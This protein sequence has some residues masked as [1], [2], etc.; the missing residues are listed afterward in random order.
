LVGAV[1]SLI[2]V[3]IVLLAIIFAGPIV[4]GDP[5]G[6]LARLGTGVML[7]LALALTPLFCSA[8]CGGVLIFTRRLQVGRQIEL[9]A[10]SGRIVNVRL[11]DTVL[12][13]NDGSEVRVPHLRT[14]LTP[15]RVLTVE[16]RRSVELSITTRIEP[17]AVIEVLRSAASEAST[18]DDNLVELID[19]DADAACYR[20]SVPGRDGR[21]TNELRLILVLALAREHIELARRPRYVLERSAHG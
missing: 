11:L 18:A 17:S 6:V 5:Q 8:V 21:S 20:V 4:S 9:G 16:P 14:L 15:L 2:R 13:D 10:L 1:S 12:R 7:G 3:L 19:I